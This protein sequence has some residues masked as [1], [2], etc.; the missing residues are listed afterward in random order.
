MI[1]IMATTIATTQ[2]T[3]DLSDAVPADRMKTAVL[4]TGEALEESPE[5]HGP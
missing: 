4:E 5:K 3:A 1:T 2:I